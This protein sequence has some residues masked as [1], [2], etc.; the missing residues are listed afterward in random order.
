MFGDMDLVFFGG[1]LRGNAEVTWVTDD[2]LYRKGLRNRVFGMTEW[3]QPG[4]GRI[5]LNSSS[6]FDLRLPRLSPFEQMWLTML[7]EMWYVQ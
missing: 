1:W 6:I 7:H 4:K 5:H 2:D 3:L